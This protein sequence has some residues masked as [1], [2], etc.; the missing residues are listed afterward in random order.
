MLVLSCRGSSMIKLYTF[1][2]HVFCS[3]LT[4]HTGWY[5]HS[6]NNR[7]GRNMLLL[8]RQ[9]KHKKYLTLATLFCSC[10]TVH[11]GCYHHSQNNGGGRYMLLLTRQLKHARNSNCT[12]LKNRKPKQITFSTIKVE[13]CVLSHKSYASKRCRGNGKQCRP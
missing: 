7:G 3:C 11:I 9:L 10:L 12:N 6:Q 13:Q 5:H 8:T 4:V 1:T 2:V